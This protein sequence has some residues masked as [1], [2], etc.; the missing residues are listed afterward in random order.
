VLAFSPADRGRLSCWSA[1]CWR[2]SDRSA[3][4]RGDRQGAADTGGSLVAPFERLS[5][6]L[7]AALRTRLD[8]IPFGYIETEYFGGVG[9]QRAAA[10]RGAHVLVAPREHQGVVNEVLRA[11]GVVRTSACDEWDTAG[12]ADFRNNDAIV[13]R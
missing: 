4:S 9:W 7:L 1:L 11:L 10:W 8:D 12:L 3:R 5:S 2:C 6:S 13:H